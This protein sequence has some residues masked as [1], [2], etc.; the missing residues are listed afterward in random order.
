MPMTGTTSIIESAISLRKEVL[1][2]HWMFLREITP[3][4]CLSLLKRG[5]L[6]P[7][8]CSFS[9]KLKSKPPGGDAESRNDAFE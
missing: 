4:Y 6:K 7:P 9:N 8:D 2:L 1:R 5:S 3:I